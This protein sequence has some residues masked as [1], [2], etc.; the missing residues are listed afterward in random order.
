MVSSTMRISARIAS[1]GNRENRSSAN[2]ADAG[3]TSVSNDSSA[4][5]YHPGFVF[6][7]FSLCSSGC[8]GDPIDILLLLSILLFCGALVVFYFQRKVHHRILETRLHHRI[9]KGR[10]TYSDLKTPAEPLFSK[11]Y[12]L[13]GKPDYIIIQN[14][15]VIP[16]EYKSSGSSKPQS[17]HILQLAAYCQLVEDTSQE[18]VPYGIL[19]Y[20]QNDFRIPF[21]PQLR[22]ELQETIKSMRSLVKHNR[23]PTPRFD[24][25]K[26]R[27]CSM[28][29]YCHL[30]KEKVF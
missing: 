10:V 21:N 11:K 18:F 3:Y 27:S 17:H 1:S 16:V 9:P 30:I 13:T 22:F 23:I 8:T 5:V 7:W 15:H 29:V 26:C 28:K 4:L 14:S 20:D 6:H 24:P 25:G 19:V 2:G 12:L